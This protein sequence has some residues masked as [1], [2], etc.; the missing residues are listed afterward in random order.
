MTRTIISTLFLGAAM[1]GTSASALTAEQ[2]VEKEIVVRNA[3]GSET[4]KRTSAEL[5]TPGENIVY[6]LNYFN[7]D[8]Q[9]A[10]GIVL[11][12]P[13]PAEVKYIEGSA[14]LPAAITAYS[15]DGGKT[16]TPRSEVR[17]KNEDGTLRTASAEDITHVRWSVQQAVAPG[18]SGSLSFKGQLK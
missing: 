18:A 10:D 2:T 5:V 14:D 6:S 9:P 3:D 12:M 17:I 16:F 13:V 1:I 7:D 15:A 8:A 11:V 4:L